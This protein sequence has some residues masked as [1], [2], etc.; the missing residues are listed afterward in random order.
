[1]TE[2]LKNIGKSLGEKV[3]KP[4][5]LDRVRERI[6]DLNIEVINSEQIREIEGSVI[7]AP[8]HTR[9][10][11]KVGRMTGLAPDAIILDEIIRRNVGKE[12]KIVAK[13]DDGREVNKLKATSSQLLQGMLKGAGMVPILKNPGSFNREFIR[14]IKQLM[15]SGQSLLI[16][17]EGDWRDS[18]YDFSKEGV[19][20]QPGTANISLKYGIPVVPVFLSGG[21]NLS[22]N[23]EMKVQFGTPISSEGK[24][25]VEISD[26]IGQQIQELQQL[27]EQKPQKIEFSAQKRE[28]YLNSLLSKEEREQKI[29]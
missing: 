17:P 8:N 18:G 10:L 22:V 24:T 28:E 6:G 5:V 15:E 19:D 16:F 11:S 13:G 12:A 21:D 27:L 7:F 1:M 25:K 14:D 29:S 9:P 23:S 2:I 4:V 20:V 26:L 3:F